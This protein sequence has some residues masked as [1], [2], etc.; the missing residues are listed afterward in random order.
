M[1]CFSINIGNLDYD[2]F[3]FPIKYAEY[4]IKDGII[5]I[6][7]FSDNKSQFI[8]V[9]E[10]LTIKGEIDIS[11]TDIDNS[12]YLDHQGNIFE[13][14]NIISATNNIKSNADIIESSGNLIVNF[15]EEISVDNISS[16]RII[17]P[18]GALILQG[19][20]QKDIYRN[21][22]EINNINIPSGL[23]ILTAYNDKSNVLL[24]KKFMF[25]NR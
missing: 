5:H 11:Q 13:V 6:S 1:V 7:Y 4:I 14:K 24:S 2:D 9:K 15:D 8:N 21:C 16:I 19:N 10:I 17:N 18:Y 20:Y 12:I 23:Y 22:L 3:I 25:L